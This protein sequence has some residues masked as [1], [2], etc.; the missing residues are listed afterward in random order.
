LSDLS[1]SIKAKRE[2]D[3]QEVEQWSN[4]KNREKAIRGLEKGFED[5]LKK[6]GLPGFEITVKVSI[7]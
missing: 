6:S 4:L 2:L 1:L 5:V 7:K 3:A